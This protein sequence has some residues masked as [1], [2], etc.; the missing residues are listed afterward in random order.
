MSEVLLTFIYESI[1]PLTITISALKQFQNQ[2]VEEVT[3]EYIN[4]HYYN[5]VGKSYKAN[6]Q[7]WEPK[8]GLS[9]WRNQQSQ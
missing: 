2:S 1:E 7:A 6:D 3:L 8:H 9:T 4:E 5:W